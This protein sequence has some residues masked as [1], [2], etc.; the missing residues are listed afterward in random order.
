MNH[1]R[2]ERHLFA[3]LMTVAAVLLAFG[4]YKIAARPLP[5]AGLSFDGV[6]GWLL[7]PAAFVAGQVHRGWKHA[8]GIR[9]SHMHAIHGKGLAALLIVVAGLLIFGGIR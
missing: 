4:A 7:V 9:Q 5:G 6:S 8:R 3:A 1:T 2:A